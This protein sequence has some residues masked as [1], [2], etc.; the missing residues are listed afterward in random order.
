MIEESLGGI[1]LSIARWSAWAPGLST[2]AAWEKWAADTLDPSLHAEKPDVSFVPAMLRRRLSSLSRMVF[3]VA[4]TCLDGEALPDAYVYCSRYGEYERG[5]EI[6]AGLARQESVSPAAFSHS[7]HNTSASLFS[8]DRGDSAPYTALAAGAATLESAFL[9]AWTLLKSGEAGRVLLIYHDEPLP[10]LYKGQETNVTQNCA[11]ALLLQP[12]KT[13]LETD[14]LELS[15]QG[16]PA[17]SPLPLEADD[18]ALQVVRLLINGGEPFTNDTG[19]LIWQWT[20]HARA[21]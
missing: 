10:P 17:D 4:A 19:R 20:K 8:I 2:P 7:V 13:S 16:S 21:A 3:H 14:Q 18:P 12:S 1:E 11:L 6:L 9:E 15:W 5:F